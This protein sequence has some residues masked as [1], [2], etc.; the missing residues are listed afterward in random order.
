MPPRRRPRNWRDISISN[1]DDCEA[2][3]RA[4]VQFDLLSRIFSDETKAF[5]DLQDRP[6]KLSFR[7]LYLASLLH[8][9]A[10]RPALKEKLAI[11][12]F[13]TD[14]AML[15]LLINVTRIERTMGFFP[16]MRGTKTYHPIPCLQRTNES[17]LDSSRIRT[18]LTTTPKPQ[19]T[20]DDSPAT[21]SQILAKAKAGE[22][23]PTNLPN[24]IFI[25]ATHSVKIGRDHLSGVEFKDLFVRSELSSES[26]ARAFLWLCYNY[27]EGPFTDPEDDYDGDGAELNPFS[28]PGHPG[29]APQLV[30]LSPEEAAAENVDPDEENALAV[31]LVAQREA[32]VQ[33]HLLKESE[34]KS[35]AAQ[36]AT[37]GGTPSPTKPGEETPAP[38]KLKGKRAA[39]AKAGP[40]TPLK[41]KAQAVKEEE[42]D[43]IRLRKLDEDLTPALSSGVNTPLRAIYRQERHSPRPSPPP[44]SRRFHAEPH[45][46]RYAP[47]KRS[48]PR[49]LLQHAWHIVAASDPLADSDE[50]VDDE[51]ARR[52]H[53]S[54]RLCLLFPS[55]RRSTNAAERLAVLSRLRGKAPTPEPEG[56]RAIPLHLGSWHDDLFV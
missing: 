55:S 46:H 35:K 41:R 56:L 11:S 4:D 9:S 22:V 24:L 16:E 48:R 5:S 12:A 43:E 21:P 37:P 39:N 27:Y 1:K 53:G 7:D 19:E 2:L 25:M 54:C 38:A 13:A 40:S 28:D 10:M 44:P 18:I 26:R 47:Y 36:A 14:F 17:L 20:K 42:A 51:H 23:P 32:V 50:E 34:K 6:T 33:A 30:T 45:S 49:T 3:R 52:D 15:A 31:T 8:S 29:K